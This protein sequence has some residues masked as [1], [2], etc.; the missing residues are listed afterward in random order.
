[1]SYQY[2]YIRSDL[3]ELDVAVIV[4]NVFCQ[5]FQ[6]SI[7]TLHDFTI[8]ITRKFVLLAS[9][10]MKPYVDFLITAS[11][12]W[13]LKLAYIALALHRQGKFSTLR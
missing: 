7:R 8:A 3:T 13:I 5:K 6:I 1:M 9:R 2:N 4:Y 10:C 11:K 12:F